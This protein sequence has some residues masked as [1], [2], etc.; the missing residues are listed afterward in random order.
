MVG[1]CILLLYVTNKIQQFLS[2]NQ[3]SAGIYY[4]RYISACFGYMEPSSG[5]TQYSILKHQS[6][7]QG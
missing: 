3:S 1:E 4:T 5:E 7:Y 2:R 6:H